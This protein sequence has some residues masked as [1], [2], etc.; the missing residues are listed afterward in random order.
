MHEQPSE[1]RIDSFFFFSVNWFG[2]RRRSLSMPIVMPGPLIHPSNFVETRYL[3]KHLYATSTTVL[4]EPFTSWRFATG[5]DK[6]SIVWKNL[7]ASANLVTQP[8]VEVAAVRP[9][10][11]TTLGAGNLLGSTKTGPGESSFNNTSITAL[12]GA[13][14]WFRAGIA[15]YSSTGV[16]EADVGFRACW[17]QLG[18]LAGMGSFQL[19]GNDTGNRIFKLTRWMRQAFVGK[20]K[21]APVIN[22][23]TGAATNLQYEFVQ[24]TAPTSIQQPNSAGWVVPPS[25]V[26]NYAT[27][28][29]SNSEACSPEF[30]PHSSYTGDTWIRF[31]VF[32]DLVAGTNTLTTATLSAM[33][34]V[35]T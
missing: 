18:Q 2:H 25:G 22:G 33:V 5:V 26:S 6:I 28:T 21:W 31:A 24:Q 23:L 4:H 32:A 13:A 30:S 3:E 35:R 15:Y 1:T 27:I 8:Y 11:P 16:S 17:N 34:T 29:S 19:N 10:N 12:T 7:Q 9:D 14:M 20:I